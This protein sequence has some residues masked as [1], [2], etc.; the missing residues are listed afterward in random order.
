MKRWMWIII[1]LVVL[2]AGFFGIRQIQAGSAAAQAAAYETITAEQGDLTA[3]IGATGIV[4]AGQSAN[5]LFETDGIVDVV[6]VALGDRVEKDQVLAVLSEDSLPSQIIMAQADLMDAQRALETLMVS[7]LSRAQAQDTFAR[8]MDAL[9][10]AE[11]NLQ[12]QQ[13]GY[14]AN[15]EV[16]ARAEANLVLAQSEVDQA[17]SAYGQVSSLPKDNP[18]RALARANLADA[19]LQRDS[20]QR[21]LN[22]Y[23]GEPD[24]IEQALLDASVA[25]AEAQLADAEREFSRWQYG[26][27][28]EEI[29]RLQAQIT[30]AQ[31]MLDLAVIR[32]PFTGTITSVHVAAGDPV[33]M[34]SPAFRLSNLENQI[35]EV[36]ISEVD[37]NQ[38]QIG[39]PAELLFDAVLNK[40][41]QGT[42]TEVGLEGIEMQGVINF[43]VKVEALDPDEWI[44][45]GLTAAVNIIV[46][47]LEDVLIVPNR[48]VRVV[49]GDRVVYILKEGIIE[50]V[51]IE[52]GASAD[53]F[54]EV[55]GGELQVGDVIVINPPATFGPPRGGPF[56]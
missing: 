30:A 10:R 55:V 52:L 15:G 6:H 56:G 16:I 33:T 5:L 8:T 53:Q 48:A 21:S 3:V 31:S 37:I 9:D 34:T 13:R 12:V 20:V 2:V 11:Y 39:Q 40:T 46:N 1:I 35:I 43:R 23:F 29:I 17:A 14:R 44:K 38:V 19:R 26:V 18:Q 28:Q 45:P 4:E 51:V 32:A 7:G 36:E 25:L 50:P 24:E 47:Q 54:S 42:V 49:E 22:W 41:Y 27:P